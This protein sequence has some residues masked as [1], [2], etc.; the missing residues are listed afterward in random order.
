[1]SFPLALPLPVA[2]LL[3]HRPPMLM[4]EEIVAMDDEREAAEIRLTVHPDNPFLD[5]DG[6][7]DPAAFLEIVAQAAAAQ[8]GANLRREG[9][10]SEAG[11]LLGVRDF[12][13]TGAARVGDVLTVEVR[14]ASEI[15]R[16]AAVD[17][18][19]RR[20]EVPL[21]AAN[22]TVWHGTLPPVP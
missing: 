20:G 3:P 14:K 6:M 9:K 22:L 17:G 21:A 19:V 4:V 8:H 10:P 12:R 5:A 1:M 16:V 18:S 11:M 2:D 13:I 15:E 7:L